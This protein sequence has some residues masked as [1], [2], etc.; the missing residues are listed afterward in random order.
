[1]NKNLQQL[2]DATIKEIR[3]LEVVLP[4]IY[5]DIFYTKAEELNITIT[6]ND[7]EMAMI[8]ALKKI[9]HLKDETEKST[10]ILKENVT[11]AKTAIADKDHAALQIVED[12]MIDLEKKIFLLQQELYI[13]E[14]TGL[15]NRRWL[16]EKFLQQDEFRDG[17]VFAFID[18]NNFKRVNDDFGHLVGDKV[19]NVIGKVLKRIENTSAIRF[20]G[21]EFIVLSKAYSEDEMIKILHSVNQNLK[22]TKLKHH[23]Q[24]FNV[25]FAF[26]VAN[27]S[28]NTSFKTILEEA[29]KKMY[30]YKK[31]IK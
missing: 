19:L 12:N 27:F 8:Y 9:Q 11:L 21:D 2:T 1:M 24:I 26:G 16:F 30:D 23:D 29:D 3:K 5:K 14:L 20:A 18:I 4:E 6:D 17:G 25:D 22:A 15:Y 31:S 28:R 7:K 10:T 13:D